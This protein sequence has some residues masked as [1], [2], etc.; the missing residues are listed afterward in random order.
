MCPLFT[1]IPDVPIHSTRLI[2]TLFSSIHWTIAFNW[3]STSI[4]WP[5]VLNR[6]EQIKLSERIHHTLFDTMHIFKKKWT[7]WDIS[8]HEYFSTYQSFNFSEWTN[9]NLQYKMES[10]ILFFLLKEYYFDTEQF[11]MKYTLH[12]FF[13]IEQLL[14]NLYL[15]LPI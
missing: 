1:S 3:H 13:S 8:F 10:Y 7:L 14:L 15:N 6:M 2:H 4:P 11:Y 9:D 5:Q 12:F